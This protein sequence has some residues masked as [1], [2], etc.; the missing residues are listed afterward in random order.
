MVLL[1]LDG[2]MFKL[3]EHNLKLLIKFFCVRF[4]ER[5]VT[6]RMDK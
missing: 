5:G 2:A 1:G 3:K 6:F 4:H